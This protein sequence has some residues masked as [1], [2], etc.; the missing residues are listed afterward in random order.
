MIGYVW[1][2]FLSGTRIRSINTLAFNRMV[3]AH[4]G[5]GEA[6]DALDVRTGRKFRMEREGM[7]SPLFNFYCVPWRIYLGLEICQWKGYGKKTS[8]I[9]MNF[10]RR[11]PNAR[12]DAVLLA[13]LEELP[14]EFLC[15]S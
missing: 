7:G 2:F 13:T 11:E 10:G 9:M 6:S 5:K 12:D 4:L 8:W 1:F 3:R 15:I 14:E